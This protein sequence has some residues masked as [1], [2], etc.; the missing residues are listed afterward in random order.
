MTGTGLPA[1]PASVRRAAL[2]VVCLAACL[3][4][5]R[6]IPDY[7]VQDDFGGMQLIA[8]KPWHTFPR[9]F[10]MPWMEFI[11]GYT[12]DEIRPFTALSYQITSSPGPSVP[13]G[14]HLLNIALHAGNAL[15]VLAIALAGARLTWMGATTAALIFALLPLGAESV[16]WI[17]GR[18]DSLPAFFYL[19]SFYAYVRWRNTG[20]AKLYVWSLVWLFAAL[21]SKQNTITMIAAVAG[22]DAIVERRRIRIA[23]EWVRPYVPFAVLTIGFLAL[24]Y[25]LLGEVLRENRLSAM[26]WQDAGGILARHMHRMVWWDPGAIPAR[27]AIFAAVY[28]AGSAAAIALGDSVRRRTWL[29][30]LLYFGPVWL[31]LGLAPT[32]AAGYE[33]PRHAY[34]AAAGYAIVI[35]IAFDALSA[36]RTAESSPSRLR[37]YGATAATLAIVVLYGVRLH[38]E[39][40]DW[41][42]RSAVSELAVRELERQVQQ[43]PQGSLFVVG[44]PV[45][46]WEWGAPFVA[47]PPYTSTDL[48]QRAG[49]VVPER[50]HCCRGKY[51]IAETRGT[52][53][54]WDRSRGPIVALNILPTGEVR[55]LTDADDPELRTLVAALVGIQSPGN[56]DGAIID[57]LR[58]YVAGRGRV[59]RPPLAPAP[60]RR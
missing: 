9:W 13:D 30:S 8:A 35:G 10:T 11:W 46:S 49:I 55:R 7:F 5:L 38:R 31:A 27:L 25:V 39:V 24:R 51:W 32:I 22:Y 14:H 3:P 36:S 54:A 53:E 23:W 41:R 33:S 45:P 60:A 18:V 20:R 6:T 17:T 34:L 2:V 16:A 47:R 42:L 15:L 21:F 29:N 1:P 19:L 57:V 28:A 56:L 12:P 59:I 37:L 52:L 48:S 26:R 50:L 44:V 58:K 40:S 43:A 4:Y